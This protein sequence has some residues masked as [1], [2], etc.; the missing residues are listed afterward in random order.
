MSHAGGGDGRVERQ[1]QTVAVAE[2]VAV[3]EAT[4]VA[5]ATL[6]VAVGGDRAMMT[7]LLRR[8]PEQNLHRG[9]FTPYLKYFRDVGP[10][11]ILTGI[12]EDFRRKLGF[13]SREAFS[14]MIT[15]L[16]RGHPEQC[17]QTLA[18]TH[19]T[20]H[21]KSKPSY[22][23]VWALASPSHVQL[24]SLLLMFLRCCASGLGVLKPSWQ[25]LSFARYLQRFRTIRPPVV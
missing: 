21:F 2:A 10:S 4:A 9:R 14:W 7:T 25:H 18:R 17:L 11:Y 22:A 8:H 16:F 3:E 15:T 20:H 6:V 12:S 24:A 19:T 1:Q 5:V 23:E 13:G